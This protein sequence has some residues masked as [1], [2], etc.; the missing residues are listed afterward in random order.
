[1]RMNI[2]IPLAGA[3]KRFRDAGYEL[4]KPLINVLGKPM[5]QRVVENLPLRENLIFLVNK[6][7]REDYGIGDFLKA[8]RPGSEIISV[9]RMTEGAACTCLLAKHLIDNDAPLLIANSDQLMEWDTAH[10]YQQSQKELDGLIFTYN[11]VAPNNSFVEIDGNGFV[12]RVAEKV[13]ISNLA[14]CG[15]YFFKK[16]RSFISAAEEMIAKNI[17][18][19]NEF[20][21]CPSYSHL[22]ERGLKVGIYPIR[23]HYHLGTP[24]DLAKY[25]LENPRVRP[26]ENPQ[27]FRFEDMIRGWFVGNFSKTAWHSKCYEVAYHRHSKGDKPAP[28]YHLLGTEITFLIEGRLRI[29]DIVFGG[30]DIFITNPGEIVTPEYLEDSSLIV[31]KTPSIPGDKYVSGEQ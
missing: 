11:S 7:H 20:Y 31:I 28:H 17:R 6:Q 15:V 14:S 3:G 30:G 27:R 2:V 12:T 10:F 1:V 21:V 29:G 8:M 16:G 24:E 5:I 9:D 22:I 13:V 4:P 18:T 25:V 26:L 19:N 23:K